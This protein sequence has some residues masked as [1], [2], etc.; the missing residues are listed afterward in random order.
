MKRYGQVIGIKHEKLEE[1]KKLHSAVWPD[2]L[3]IIT[4]CNI[5]N[6]S[7]YYKNGLLFAYF[8][9]TGSDFD[10]DMSKMAAD[11]VTQLWW[12]ACPARILLNLE[13]KANGG[14][15]W[16]KFFIWINVFAKRSPKVEKGSMPLRL[17]SR[18]NCVQ[19]MNMRGY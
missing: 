9:Y 4:Q 10:T 3:K 19:Y 8:E 13:Q 11:P 15:T 7:I 12:D 16:K 5:M 18:R 17:L 2:V 1:Y 14:Q 6:Y